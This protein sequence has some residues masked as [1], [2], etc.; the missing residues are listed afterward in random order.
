MVEV[1]TIEE[2]KKIRIS[3]RIVAEILDILKKKIHPGISTGKLNEIAGIE[4]RQRKSLPAFLGYKGYPATLCVSINEEVV[5]GVP[6]YQRIINDG[7][8]VS[9]DL[10]CI[11]ENYYGDAALTIAAGR[12][13]KKGK[14]LIEVAERAL[15]KGISVIKKGA[16]L[17]DISSAI[18]NF[19]VLNG[20]SVIKEFTGHGIG[21]HLHE[22]PAIANFG[23][24]GSG[25]VL[26][27]G[28]VL[29]I[30]PMV[31]LGKGDVC[32]KKDGWTAV[33]AD[34]SHS[35]HFEH[36]VCVTDNGCEILSDFV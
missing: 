18:E 29:A 8:I 33:T 35:A 28:M 9:L 2:I 24:A 23:K 5:H 14:K 31:C 26:E 11:F 36:T 25:I 4:I 34:G 17:G 16:R 7:D 10:G 27:T 22:E 1:K 3:S 32:I 13:D 19:V 15:Y 20:M 12:V 30:E 6:D 21:R